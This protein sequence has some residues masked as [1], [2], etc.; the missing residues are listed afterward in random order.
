VIWAAVEGF[1]ILA[2][3][4]K[5]SLVNASRQKSLLGADLTEREREILALLVKG[6]SNREIA[7]Q[8]VISMA[9]VK[10]HMTNLFT[11]LG[12]KNRV[13]AVSITLEHNLVKKG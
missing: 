13:E 1:S 7:D 6:S 5:E 10:L 9:T 12:A 3:E 2:P 8:L 4:A 11:K